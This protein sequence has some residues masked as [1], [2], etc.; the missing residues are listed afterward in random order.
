M[1]VYRY[2][3]RKKKIYTGPLLITAGIASVVLFFQGNG[4]LLLKL[5]TEAAVAC[6]QEILEWY[7]PGLAYE[8]ADGD[9]D[10]LTGWLLAHIFPLGE[11]QWFGEEYQTQF[12]SELSYEAIL[13]RE[14]DR[15]SVV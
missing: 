8:A 3:D 4:D 11:E 2:R 7:L 15:K 13:A 14:A 10:G 6:Y 9:D 1:R 12:E 5:K